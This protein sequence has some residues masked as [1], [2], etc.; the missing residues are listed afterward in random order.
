VTPAVGAGADS[1]AIPVAALPAQPGGTPP[2]EAPPAPAALAQGEAAPPPDGLERLAF[3]FGQEAWV[4]VRDASGAIIFSRINKAG[5]T[6]EVQ[7]KGP[8]ALVVGNAQN[9]KLTH[10]GKAVD[11][12]P[13]TKVSVARLTLR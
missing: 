5:T 10:N 13:H 9:V 3:S 6:Q 7:G 12:A 8:F 4:E 1:A 2:A 11:L